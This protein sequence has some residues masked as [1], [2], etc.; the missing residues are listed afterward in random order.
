[1]NLINPQDEITFTP[2]NCRTLHDIV[3]YAHEFSM[4]EMFRLTEHEVQG[5]AKVVDLVS[6][7]PLKIRLLDLGGGVNR[8][9]RRKVRPLQVLSQPFQAFWLGLTYRPWSSP[10]LED[11]DQPGAP[12]FPDALSQGGGRDRNYAVLSNHYLNLHLCL[13]H[14]L[15]MVEAYITA[16]VND[17]YLTFGFRETGATPELR[18][19]RARLLETILNRLELSTQRK[20][21]LIEARLGKY[22]P[23]PMADCLTRL[24]KLTLY[25]NQLDIS[26]VSD[27]MIDWYVEDF[28]GQ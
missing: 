18:A 20:G 4:R 10:T 28:I 26:L 24:G 17:N 1:L 3:R 21:D 19:I 11:R 8:G 27:S 23:E 5:G 22:A 16:Q 15:F 12:T 6:S 2:E 14:L 9:W 13:G 7:L 25:I